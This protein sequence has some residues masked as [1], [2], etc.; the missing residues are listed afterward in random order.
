MNWGLQ[1]RVLPVINKLI[2][3]SRKHQADLA[4]NSSM[5][6]LRDDRTQVAGE[7]GYIMTPQPQQQL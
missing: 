2:S 6:V 3:D 7:S 1:I 5:P 4:F